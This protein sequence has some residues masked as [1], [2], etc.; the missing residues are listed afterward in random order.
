M[1]EWIN[2][3]L[4]SPAFSLTVLLAAFLLGLL[5]SIAS[6]CCSLPIFG[7]LVG[8]SASREKTDRKATLLSALFFIFGTIAALI[9]LGSVAGLITKAAQSSLGRY[10]KLFTGIV[11]IFFG[12]ASLRLLPFRIPGRKAP[13]SSERPRGLIGAAVFGFAVGGGV[14][15]FSLCCNPGIFLILGVVVIKG[16]SLWSAIMLITYAIGFGLPLAAIIL[17]VSLGKMAVRAKKIETVIRIAAGALL[18]AV[19]FYFLATL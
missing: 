8:Y 14:S 5:S 13:E 17:G 1:Q 18:I 4:E 7:A 12:L 15:V 19:G 10:W 11:I 2:Q 3:T 16:W 6:A 9:V